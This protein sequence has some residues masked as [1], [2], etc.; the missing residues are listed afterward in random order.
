[1]YTVPRD[2][3]LFEA[4]HISSG[5]LIAGEGSHVIHRGAFKSGPAHGAE[6]PPG[7]EMILRDG[8]TWTQGEDMPFYFACALDADYWHSRK[9][10]LLVTGASPDGKRPT[11]LNMNYGSFFVGALRSDKTTSGDNSV[12]ISDGALLDKAAVFLAQ[13]QGGDRGSITV[14]GGARVNALVTAVAYES[15]GTENVITITGEGTVWDNHNGNF[16]IGNSAGGPPALRNS[17]IVTDHAK[18][19]NVGNLNIGHRTGDRG[20]V[21]TGNTFTVA[22]GGEVR[23]SWGGVMIGYSGGGAPVSGNALVLDEGGRFV[24]R[25]WIAVGADNESSRDNALSLRGG[26]ISASSL[27]VRPG[28]NLEVVIGAGGVKPVILAGNAALAPG[29]RIVARCDDVAGSGLFHPV[30]VSSEGIIS[31]NGVLLTTSQTEYD[32][33]LRLNEDRN[34]LSLGAFAR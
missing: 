11:T 1:V 28:N 31:T 21:A 5:G 4:L 23:M 24:T 26:E 14:S 18:L 32:F 6:N 29:S 15:G 33:K 9:H 16:N 8:A 25:N 13:F 34:E 2:Y 3:Y 27:S 7:S 17:V 30:I 10:R 12:T 20:N 22:A 19:L